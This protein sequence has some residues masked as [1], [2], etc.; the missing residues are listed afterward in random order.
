MSN[1]TSIGEDPSTIGK[2]EKKTSR[3]NLTPSKSV[4]K[5]SNSGPAS[6]E[7][8]ANSSSPPSPVPKVIKLSVNKPSENPK[9]PEGNL[10]R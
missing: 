7:N 10:S 5:K 4:E 2:L 9:R 3:K 1:K 6:T 8:M